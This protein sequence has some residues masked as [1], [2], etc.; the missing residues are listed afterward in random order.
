MKLSTFIQQ[1]DTVPH[2]NFV[3]AKGAAIP[4]HF[5]ITE[6]GLNTRH[7]IDCGGTVRTEKMISLQVWVADDTEHRLTP[8]KLKTIIAMAEPI[9]G[10][11][12]L[13]VEIE[14]QLETI[15]R[16]D[17]AIKGNNFLFLPKHTTCLAKDACGAPNKN[18]RTE[19]VE[20]AQSATSSCTPGGGCC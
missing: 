6:A 17:L 16:F 10:N 7:F 2:L 4:A 12:D 8:Q 20:L 1:L 5:H 19:M 9:I 18:L 14:Y 15:G 3:D 11:E 13:E